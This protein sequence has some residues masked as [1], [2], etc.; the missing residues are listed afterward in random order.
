MPNS[1]GVGTIIDNFPKSP[2]PYGWTKRPRV[3]DDGYDLVSDEAAILFGY[4]IES[5]D[6]LVTVNIY[7]ADGQ[8]MVESLPGGLLLRGGSLSLN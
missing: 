4:K 5:G 2:T 3:G 8:L 1:D 6:C 7:S